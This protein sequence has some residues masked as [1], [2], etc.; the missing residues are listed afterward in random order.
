MKYIKL[1]SNYREIL[2]SICLFANLY[3][4]TLPAQLYYMVWI[5]FVFAIVKMKTYMAGERAKLTLMLIGIIIFSTIINTAVLDARW[6]M[7]CIILYITLCKTSYKFYKFKERFLFFSLFGYII[8][9]LL[10]NYAHMVNINYQLKHW[11]YIGQDFTLSF[12]GFTNNPMWLSAACGIGVIFLSYWM[13][14]LWNNKKRIMALLMLPLIFLTLQTLVWGASRSALG[15]S[16]GASVL[17]IFLSNKKIIRT[18]VM[19]C[20]FALLACIATPILMADSEKMQSKKGGMEFVDEDGETSRTQLWNMRIKEFE[21]SP[22]WG[23][24]F[25]V[26]GIDDE[27]K[28]GRAETGSGWLT[29]LSQT[30]IIGFVLSILIVFRAILPL[31]LLRDNTRMALYSA[32]LAYLCLHTMFEA[33]LFQSGWYLCFVFWLTVSVL[34]D[35]RKFYKCDIV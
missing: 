10:N 22:L 24:G 23:I 16:I 31:R 25:G 18:F 30:G 26:T 35:Y 27:A 14:R 5:V 12:S 13:N 28:T 17:L 20:S 9:G 33:Y 11:L 19:L 6:V 8:T 3:S 2:L 34:D 1:F 21:S 7:M 4:Y 29:V 15:I 32:I